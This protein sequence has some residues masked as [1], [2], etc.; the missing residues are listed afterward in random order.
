MATFYLNFPD[1]GGK[2][3]HL[4][5]TLRSS[6]TKRTRPDQHHEFEK[7]VHI[8]TNVHTIPGIGLVE[9]ITVWITILVIDYIGHLASPDLETQGQI[10]RFRGKPW[11][12]IM[13]MSGALGS[14]REGLIESSDPK[15][16]LDSEDVGEQTRSGGAE[17][18]VASQIRSRVPAGVAQSSTYDLGGRNRN[19]NMEGVQRSDSLQIA[20]IPSARNHQLSPASFSRKPSDEGRKGTF[21][22]A[23][24]PIPTAIVLV[25]REE[26]RKKKK[27]FIGLSTSMI[28]FRPFKK[29]VSP[30]EQR[31]SISDTATQPTQPKK[32]RTENQE[33]DE[34]C[35]ASLSDKEQETPPRSPDLESR[36]MLMLGM[37]PE[38]WSSQPDLSLHGSYIGMP[39]PTRSMAKHLA[40]KKSRPMMRSRNSQSLS[41]RFGERS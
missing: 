7:R 34:A 17:R 4:V 32:C 37:N 14:L 33:C 15:W 26:K 41:A 3:T 20:V 35:Q 10:P 2:R 31:R 22:P 5:L 9:T 23:Y 8:T 38:L 12:G 29:P 21:R 28:D 40:E 18:C 16:L 27:S 13:T 11:L 6:L 24:E 19:T 36:R 1:A 30:T 25:A 39:W